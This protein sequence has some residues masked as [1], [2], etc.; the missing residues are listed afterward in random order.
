[1]IIKQKKTKKMHNQGNSFIMVVATLSFLAVLVAAMLVAVALCYR[2]K[3]YDINARDNFYY[4]EQAMD[5]IYAGV[6]ADAMKH[7]N[8]AYDDTVEVLVY[9]DANKKAYVTMDDQE[10]NNI[11]KNTYM[12]LIKNDANYA[13]STAVNT[14][15][16]SFMSN[17]YNSTSKPEGVLLSVGNV[18]STADTLTIHNLVLKREAVY[19]TINTRKTDSGVAPAGDT[20]VQTITTDLVI[21]KPEFDVRFNTIDSDLS[22]LYEFIIV[23]DKGMEIHNATSK[24][25][26]TGNIYAASDF[27]NK[28]Y[29]TAVSSYES[30]EARYLAC[31]GKNERSMYS[32]IY[33]NGSDVIL[34]SDKVIVPGTIAAFNSANLILSGSSQSKYSVSEVWADGIVLGGYSLLK[35][36]RTADEPE[37]TVQGSVVNMRANAY[38]YDDLE[39]NAEASEYSL[40]GQ[41]FGYNYASTDNRTYVN[42]CVTANGGR[43]YAD[44]VKNEA[45]KDG[46]TIDGQAHYNSSA[47]IING[48][49]SSLDL[50]NVSNMYIAGQAYIETSKVTKKHDKAI[51]ADGKETANEYQVKNKNGELESV[52]F[53]TYDYPT[54]TPANGDKAA[55]NYTID[56]QTVEDN[57]G[58]DKADKVTG[59]NIQDYRTGEA[60]SVK[61]NQLAYI[62][63][64]YITDDE[65]GLYFTIPPEFMNLDIF[66]DTWKITKDEA[67]KI[68]SKIPI[69]K[70]VV[71]GKVYY[72]FD[73]STEATNKATVAGG[74]TSDVM[75][76]FIEGY[77]ELFTPDENGVVAGET[78]G[79]TDITDYDYFK[80]KML[81]VNTTYSEDEDKVPTY[82][83]GQFVKKK[84]GEPTV[85]TIY[86]NSAITVKNGNTFTI[87]AKSSAIGPL[88]EAQKIIDANIDEQNK[89]RDS[90]EKR[91]AELAWGDISANNAQSSANTISKQLQQQYKEVKWTLSAMSSN[92]DAVNAAH[93]MNESEITPINYYFHFN[94]IEDKVVKLNSG[95][96]VWIDDG[97]VEI[98]TDDFTNGNVKGLVI[99]KGDVT[100]ADDVD[101]FEGLIVSGSKIIVNDSLNL[102]ANAEIVKTILRECDESQQ[103]TDSSKNHFDVCELFQQY[104]SVY[105]QDS[106][107]DVVETEETK[108]ISAVQFEDV[109]SFN[110]WKKNVD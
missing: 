81:S 26:I 31:D 109:L 76:K 59:T 94:K 21:S 6:G 102:M 46:A 64:K 12:Q 58:K 68:I 27:Y 7:L 14:H 54:M 36:N 22:D 82:E 103:Y 65:T 50:S 93:T 52:K 41:Y 57:K 28:D 15:L 90:S 66:T 79:L 84:E 83:N 19:S 37:G 104:Q 40:V 35:S 10:A 106:S 56:S 100:F 95:Y 88:V 96:K 108:S 45:I 67:G 105:K 47:I 13:N 53:N 85:G 87:K 3:A 71:S 44:S 38:I 43:V 107:S 101:S 78:A 5:E 98:T 23:A 99:C 86:S 75:N 1:M 32:G 30:R 110:N 51:D 80:V 8:S 25:N 20:F 33:I 42:T 17:V 55:D 60:I 39:L 4:L 49:N 11:L 34:S 24:V 61:S 9:Y 63:T 91:S 48:Q 89:Y 72:F 16:K 69:I 73:F 70:T 97:D 62:P 2:L 92:P 77:A 18:S 74:V 29:A